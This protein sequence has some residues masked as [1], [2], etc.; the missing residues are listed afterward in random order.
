MRPSLSSLNFHSGELRLLAILALA[1]VGI[2]TGH[3]QRIYTIDSNDD[4]EQVEQ[5]IRDDDSAQLIVVIK[6]GEYELT[7]TFHINRSQVTLIGESAKLVLAPG[8]NKPVIAIGT[9]EETPIIDSQIHDI[10][11]TGISIDGSKETQTNELDEDQPWIRNNAIDVRAVKG[12]IVRNVTCNN[13]RSGGLVISWACQNV[14]VE[15]SRFNH[16]YFDGVAYYASSQVTTIDC[17]MLK[18]RSAGISLDNDLSD[19]SFIRCQLTENGDVGVFA[20][21]CRNLRFLECNIRKSENWALFL[22]HDQNGH[23]VHQTTLQN[24]LI[25]ENNGGLRLA[26]ETEKQSSGIRIISTCFS[27]NSAQGRNDVS[28]AGVEYEIIAPALN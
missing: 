3:A 25:T 16:N 11:I 17:T 10:I 14:L 6:P 24:C 8:V 15:G 5:S 9:Q 20:R 19:V 1:L 2:S 7:D 26:S 23:G 28:S 21:H 18:N 4:F 12:L 22:A 27:S 13:A